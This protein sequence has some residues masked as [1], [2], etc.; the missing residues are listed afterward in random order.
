MYPSNQ[1]IKTRIETNMQ[2]D[3]NSLL[4]RLGGRKF[5]AF[6]IITITGVLIHVFSSRG[7]TAEFT[8]L[9]LGAGGVFA[10]ANTLVT[11][12]TAGRAENGPA[13]SEQEEVTFHIDPAPMAPPPSVDIAPM[14]QDL[15]EIKLMQTQ[16]LESLVAIQQFLANAIGTPRKNG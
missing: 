16:A 11:R 14:Q 5:L 2:K 3:S 12:G 6:L 9:L 10:A 7:V 4:E 8:A 15:A 1:N 13:E